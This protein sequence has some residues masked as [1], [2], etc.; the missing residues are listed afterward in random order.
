MIRLFTHF[1]AFS[2]IFLAMSVRRW[3]GAAGQ[4]YVGAFADLTNFPFGILNQDA[5]QLWQA[6]QR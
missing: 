1:I 3:T 6:V 2:E 4:A 5:R